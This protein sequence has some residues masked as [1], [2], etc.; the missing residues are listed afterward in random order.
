[1]NLVYRVMVLVASC[2]LLSACASGPKYSEI[3]SSIPS[4]EAKDGRIYFYRT[5]NPIGS[6][7]Q[8]SVKLNDETVGKSKPGGFFFVDRVPGDYEVVLS[9]EVDKKLTFTLPADEERYV[10]MTVGLG[11]LVY[12]VFPELVD[13]GVGK[14]ALVKLRYTGDLV[15]Q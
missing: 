13:A 5:G 6:A 15:K 8:P 9:T 12:R 2:V 10:K 14:E 7:I 4:L 1:M 3:A 11:V